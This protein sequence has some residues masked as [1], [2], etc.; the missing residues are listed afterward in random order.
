ML[1]RARWPVLLSPYTF[2]QKLS[3][4]FKWRCGEKQVIT[5][6]PSRNGCSSTSYAPLFILYFSVLNFLRPWIRA[7][8]YINTPFLYDHFLLFIISSLKFN[9]YH[10]GK[11]YMI[12]SCSRSRPYNRLFIRAIAA[13]YNSLKKRH[14][15]TFLFGFVGFSF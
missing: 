10:H 8:P 14:I 12:Y 7:Y 11:K 1:A 2:Q 3:K 15:I 9:L 4:M 13:I 6:P 5:R